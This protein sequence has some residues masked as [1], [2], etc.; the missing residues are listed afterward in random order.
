MAKFTLVF[1]NADDDKDFLT[2]LDKDKDM[3]VDLT[4][5]MGH[6]LDILK[7]ITGLDRDTL[8]IGWWFDKWI[9]VGVDTP[10]DALTM[11]DA[12]PVVDSIDMDPT[13]DS[14]DWA[15]IIDFMPF[16]IVIDKMDLTKLK[17][18]ISAIDWDDKFIDKKFW[19]DTADRKVTIVF[20][21]TWA[22]DAA[23]KKIMKLF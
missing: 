3:R 13:K 1:G 7:D 17:D 16:A 9:A 11:F 19:I 10:K 18:V 23:I 5:D 2:A 4:W 22:A 6:D 12:A 20:D 21:K 15:P 14:I 8:T